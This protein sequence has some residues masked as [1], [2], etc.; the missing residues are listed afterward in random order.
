MLMA[1]VIGWLGCAA[2][3]PLLDCEVPEA[4]DLEGYCVLGEQDGA[5]AARVDREDCGSDP[6]EPDWVAHGPGG[7]E[8]PSEEVL[9]AEQQAYASCWRAAYDTVRGPE[10]ADT[11][12]R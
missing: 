5:E 4:G 2:P 10:S 12:C 11:G 3:E 6:S 9:Q 7:C 8:E 1:W